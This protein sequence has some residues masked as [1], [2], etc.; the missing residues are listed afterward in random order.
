MTAEE[1]KAIVRR[2][3]EE[4]WNANNPDILD[5]FMAPDVFNHNAVPE[6]QHG[7]EGAKHIHRWVRGG[8]P[9]ARMDIED[10]IAE[11]DKVAAYI[12]SSGTHEGEFVGIAPTGR[13]FSVK[14]VHWFRLA[15]GKVVEQWSV[16][17]DLGQMQQLGAIPA[18]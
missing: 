5:E 4:S 12:T 2:M 18:P 17:D 1:N 9:D 3:I 16:R 7:I 13:R 8:F 15:G 10:M 11:A 14:H 6:H